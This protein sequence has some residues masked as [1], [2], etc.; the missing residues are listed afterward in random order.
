M[1]DERNTAPADGASAP[2]NPFQAAANMFGGMRPS[3]DQERTAFEDML[4]RKSR[5]L[6]TY[7]PNRRG[8]D[9]IIKLGNGYRIRRFDSR[10]WTLDHFHA[11]NANNRFTKDTEPKWYRIKVYFSNL[12][13]ALRWC[14]EH[15]LLADQSQEELTLKEALDRAERI[16]DGLTAGIEIDALDVLE[17]A[18][19]A[20][21][22]DPEPDAEEPAEDRESEAAA[23]PQTEENGL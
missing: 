15:D 8:S 9:M 7:N 3:T 20:V 4:S 22:I 13:Y 11:P 23:E 16:A 18:A 14:Y 21:E 1:P 6:L 2:M 10:N 19:E 5:K 17:G 12:G